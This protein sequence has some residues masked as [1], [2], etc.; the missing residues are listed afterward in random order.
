MSHIRDIPLQEI[1][2]KRPGLWSEFFARLVREKPFGIIG[3]VIVFIL[4]FLG[5]FAD[6]LAPYGLDA[7]VDLIDRFSGPS[8]KHLLGADQIGRDILSRLIYGARVSMIVG[9]AA[10]CITVSV[11][12]V[13]GV[14]TGFLGGKLDLITQRFVDA[15]ITLP[16]LLILLTVMSMVGRGY[17]VLI[18]L[19]GVLSG[20]GWSRVVRSAVI[21]IKEN[22]YFLAAEALGSTMS[23]I[24][25]RHV[26]PNIM[27]PLI[28]VFSVN[29]GAAIMSEASLSFLGF[30]LPLEEPSWGGMLSHEGRR[31]MEVKP[32][33]AIWPG[34]AL[35]T[36]IYG[37]N[38][39]GDAV[40]DLLDPRLRG[41]E[42][43][44]GG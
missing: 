17:T 21:G 39:F 38:M 40:R 12:T 19:I 20:I 2:T 9:I 44:Y 25:M 15:W 6:F 26:M 18:V 33:L 35:A 28:I 36:V 5:V 27:A 32:S 3:G 4:L 31:H 16:S 14:P 42:A 11:A 13:I 7:E 1:E 22:D 29:I 34:V 37:V 10:T 41:S 23:R 30:G 8:S 24:V 43:S